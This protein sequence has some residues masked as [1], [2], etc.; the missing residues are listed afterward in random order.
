MYI[1]PIFLF[2]FFL[3]LLAALNALQK[4]NGIKHFFWIFLVYTF[5][6]VGFREKS[7]DFVAYLGLFECATSEQCAAGWESVYSHFSKLLFYLGADERIFF[8]TIAVVSIFGKAFAFRRLTK[9]WELATIFYLILYALPVEMGSIRQ[10]LSLTALL[11]FVG[12]L[13]QRRFISAI[14]SAF[15]CSTLHRSGGPAVFVTF[16]LLTVLTIRSSFSTKLLLSAALGIVFAYFIYGIVEV[17]NVFVVSEFNVINAL[18]SKLAVYMKMEE[19][20]APGFYLSVLK[21]LLMVFF[22]VW[23]FTKS[24]SF[25]EGCDRDSLLLF[26]L[27]VF[28]FF[29]LSSLPE[30]ATRLSGYFIIFEVVILASIASITRR[31]PYATASALLIA[32]VFGSAALRFFKFYFDWRENYVPYFRI[33]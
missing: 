23:I 29:S 32:S 6:M 33:H 24:S 28:L 26:V 5:L 12:F 19:R 30:F 20:L 1:D 14:I 7:N 25:R 27:G 11:F 13:R 17:L 4:E 15:L 8:L 9:H 16:F 3:G 31:R 22:F 18:Y 2:F 10:G 21:N